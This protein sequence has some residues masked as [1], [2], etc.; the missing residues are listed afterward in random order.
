MRQESGE[1]LRLTFVAEGFDRALVVSLDPR[2][3]WI[4]EAVRSWDGPLWSPHP[5]VTSAAHALVG[6]QLERVVKDPLDRSIK[7]EFTGGH[8][9]VF[10]LAP[11]TPNLVVLGE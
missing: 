10:E 1:R 6:R 9:I 2:H 11:Q 8:G 4:A 7:L 5:A 3:P